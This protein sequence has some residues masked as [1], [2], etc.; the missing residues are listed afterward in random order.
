MDSGSKHTPPETPVALL[1]PPYIY[2]Y[3]YTHLY[4]YTYI[5]VNTY[6]SVHEHTHT[7]ICLCVY[8]CIILCR[9]SAL[10]SAPG[11]GMEGSGT[12]AN[13]GLQSPTA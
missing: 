8:A 1:R 3:R 10:D 11:S 2:I 6:I 9:A 7:H 5:H 13:G 12:P 4:V